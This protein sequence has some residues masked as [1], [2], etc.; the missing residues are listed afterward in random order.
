MLKHGSIRTVEGYSNIIVTRRFKSS[1]VRKSNHDNYLLSD[2]NVEDVRSLVSFDKMSKRK[3][4]LHFAILKG[5][6]EAMKL[7]GYEDRAVWR[8]EDSRASYEKGD[9]LC[10]TFESLPEDAFGNVADWER[11]LIQ[12]R[13]HNFRGT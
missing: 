10:W 8:A 4:G 11:K 5:K 6:T 9:H 7:L 13:V 3:H 2:E 12:D 1:V